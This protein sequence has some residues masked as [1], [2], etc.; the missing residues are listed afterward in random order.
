MLCVNINRD[1]AQT[2]TPQ[3]RQVLR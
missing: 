3:I 1:M 2:A